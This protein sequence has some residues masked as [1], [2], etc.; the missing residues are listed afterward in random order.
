[1]KNYRKLAKLVWGKNKLH[2]CKKLPKRQYITNPITLA[3]TDQVATS[4]R[5]GDLPVN[6][7]K[8][9]VIWRFHKYLKFMSK[10]I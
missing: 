5:F 1:M 7:L 2:D 4:Q 10:N 9:L 6:S 3:H 8:Q